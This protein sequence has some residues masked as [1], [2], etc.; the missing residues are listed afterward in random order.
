MKTFSAEIFI[1]GI[2]PYVFVPDDILQYLFKKSGK[3]KGHIPVHLIINKQ[4]FIQHLV[5]YAGAWR[6]Y[7]NMPMRKAAGKDVGDII[8]IKIDYDETERT[9]PMHSKFDAALKKN[10]KAAAVF[11][12]LPPY[13][14]KEILRY[15]NNLKTEEALNKNVQRA[16][17]FLLGKERFIGRDKP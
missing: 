2:N 13:M 10:K 6:L 9:T 1:I 15:L 8:T 5:K 3:E 14:K 16:I 11:N 12:N 7:L 17:N 4:K